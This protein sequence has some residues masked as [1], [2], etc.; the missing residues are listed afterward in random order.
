ML[1]KAC[2]TIDEFQ[3][4]VYARDLNGKPWDLADEDKEALM[5]SI[6]DY[7]SYIERN[8]FGA[9]SRIGRTK[10]RFSPSI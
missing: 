3:P 8:L 7:L 9:K 2:I 4:K 1:V 5:E 6:N 10:P